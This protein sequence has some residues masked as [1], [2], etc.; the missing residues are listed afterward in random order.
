M[1]H[2]FIH[3]FCENCNAEHDV[4]VYCGNRFCEVC[5]T[6]RRRNAFHRI[7]FLVNN[8]ICPR[9]FRLKM[10]TLT[11]PNQ[12][13]VGQM[14]K[15]LL[16]SFRRLRQTKQ[17]INKVDGGVFVLEV[18]GRPGNWHAHLHIVMHSKWFSIETLFKLWRKCS[19]GRG[20][21]I[22]DIPKSE[23]VGYC[24]KYISKPSVPNNVL[25]TVI[26]GMKGVRMFHPFGSWHSLNVK[27]EK[28]PAVCKKCGAQGLLPLAIFT[29]NWDP[30]WKEVELPPPEDDPVVY[31]CKKTAELAFS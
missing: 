10:L 19:P 28:P 14:I 23:A 29:N 25:D 7:E 3:V 18:T 17:W 27:Y 31:S 24:I 11:I 30:F 15:V 8:A 6:G 21:W 13:D 5:C 2:Q 1:E 20:C 22:D 9:E 12:E 4:P 16:S 26:T